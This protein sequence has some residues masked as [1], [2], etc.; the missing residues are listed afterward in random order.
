VV[1][2]GGRHLDRR[3]SNQRRTTTVRN[4]FRIVVSLIRCSVAKA[5]AGPFMR[6]VLEVTF[7][8]DDYYAQA[9][10]KRRTRLLVKNFFDEILGARKLGQPTFCIAG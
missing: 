1:L 8:D 3:R 2:G 5:N 4:V 10:T 7:D 9:I 6:L